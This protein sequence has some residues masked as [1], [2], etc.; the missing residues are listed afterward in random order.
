MVQLGS[1]PVRLTD[2]EFSTL[3]VMTNDDSGPPAPSQCARS[4]HTE[5]GVKLE[6]TRTDRISCLRPKG[7][8]MPTPESGFR[9]TRYATAAVVAL[10]AATVVGATSMAYLDTHDTAGET[11]TTSTVSAPDSST[12]AGTDTAT[13]RFGSAPSVSSGGTSSH[14]TTHGS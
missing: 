6:Y 13:P 14:T 8:L 12:S 5:F 2:P 10:G 7:T 9:R 1:T 11:T 3:E 4:R